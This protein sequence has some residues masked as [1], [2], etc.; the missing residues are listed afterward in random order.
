MAAIMFG[1]PVYGFRFIGPFDSKVDA[2][3]YANEQIMELDWWVIELDD[4]EGD[5]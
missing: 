1:N 3:E 4:P 5:M 2:V